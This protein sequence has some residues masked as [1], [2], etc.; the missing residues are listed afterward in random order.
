MSTIESLGRGVMQKLL[1]VWSVTF[2]MVAASVQVSAQDKKKAP[3]GTVTA[4][5]KKAKAAK[6]PKKAAAATVKKKKATAKKKPAAAK[7][8]KQVKKK[9]KKG[10][11]E[12]ESPMTEEAAKALGDLKSADPEIVLAALGT[13]GASGKKEAASPIMELLETGPRSDVTD[14]AIY[15]LGGLYS[16]DSID[17]LIEYLRHRRADARIAAL[18]A[19]EK[20]KEEKVTQAIEQALRDSD[21]QVRATAALALGKRGDAKS[22]PVL[23]L[24]FERGVT[25]AAIAIGQLGSPDDAKRLA[26]HL[27]RADIKIMLA[28]FEEFLRRE[29]FPEE[30]KLNILNRLFDLAGPE[31]WRFAVTY[32]ATFPPDTN[33]D[34]NKLYKLVSRMVRQIK[35]K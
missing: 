2:A 10:K 5:T 29:S 16:K 35:D 25:D 3:K 6:K 4:K 33:E 32:K 17:T 15:A 23:F 9:G 7:K 21:R 34:E 14:A 31:V 24:A 11:V 12:E 20:H 13:L 28:G 22:V 8:R 1:L 19:L 26:T 30:A 27:G 18:F